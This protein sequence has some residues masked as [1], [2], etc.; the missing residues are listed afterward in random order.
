MAAAGSRTSLK[1]PGTCKVV[2]LKFEVSTKSLCCS[3]FWRR[4]L[5]AHPPNSAPG[6]TQDVRHVRN[7]RHVLARSTYVGTARVHI[8]R[9]NY[10]IN[11]FLDILLQCIAHCS[12]RHTYP[13]SHCSLLLDS[14]KAIESW[15]DTL[16]ASWPKNETAQTIQPQNIYYAKF[17]GSTAVRMIMMFWVLAQYRLVDR[18]NNGML[19][20]KFVDRCQR[21]IKNYF[22]NFF[23]T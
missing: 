13:F 1:K 17:D 14:T 9:F 16:Y 8:H 19:N 3:L 7:S 23:I 5:P 22:H 20:I 6:L 11:N 4:H 21:F 2:D 12:K 18:L 15:T 10:C